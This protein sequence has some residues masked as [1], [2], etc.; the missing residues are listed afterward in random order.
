MNDVGAPQHT[1]IVNSAIGTNRLRRQIGRENRG[2]RD[3]RR[4]AV[5]RHLGIDGQPTDS[6]IVG[7][8]TGLAVRLK[9]IFL[10]QNATQ[11]TKWIRGDYLGATFN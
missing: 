3:L 4:S 11:P 9:F 6:E 10:E 7:A 2:L 8:L 5:E 1:P